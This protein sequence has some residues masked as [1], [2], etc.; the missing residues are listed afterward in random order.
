MDADLTVDLS[1][2]V[3]GAALLLSLFALWRQHAAA[4]RANFIAEWVSSSQVAF[5]NLGPGSARDVKAIVDRGDE[6][7]KDWKKSVS[8]MPSGQSNQLMVVRA[9]GEVVAPLEL[10]WKDNRLR[11][12]SITI[13]LPDPPQGSRPAPSQWSD[14][15]KQVRQ[16]AREEIGAWEKDTVRRIRRKI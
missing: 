1:L 14:L 10:S 11:R 2:L 5:V 7:P 3:S 9:W 6:R 15:E 13:D 16:V 8:Y 4:G 12:Q